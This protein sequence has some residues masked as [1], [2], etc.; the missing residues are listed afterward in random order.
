[1]TDPGTLNISIIIPTLN[2]E[3]VIDRTLSALVEDPLL[4][5]IIADGGSADQTVALSEKKKVRIITGPPGRGRQLNCGAKAATHDILLFLHCDTALPENFQSQIHDILAQ[6][7]TVAG[8]FRLKID[9]PAALFR[10]I[11]LGA[12]L[13]STWLQLIYGDQA[14]FMKRDTFFKAGGFPEQPLLEDVALIRKLKYQ[15]RIVTASSSVATSSRR[16]RKLGILKTTLINQ[17]TLFGYFSGI[18]PE[19]LARFYYRK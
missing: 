14:L 15:G 8:A 18:S 9:D 11:E 6:P 5:I 2:E 12:N 10:L 16:W 17:L 13:R 1:M 3:K 7:K 4:E 19:K